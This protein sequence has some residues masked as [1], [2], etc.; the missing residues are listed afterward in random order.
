MF[1]VEK[2]S[3]LDSVKVK[4]DPETGEAY[5]AMGKLRASA[6]YLAFK[7]IVSIQKVGGELAGDE[8]E[9]FAIV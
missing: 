7:G 8:A 4:I 2:P 6:E 5:T 9:K 3:V 1:T